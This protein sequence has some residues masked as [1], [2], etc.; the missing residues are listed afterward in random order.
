MNASNQSVLDELRSLLTP[1]DVRT[2]PE[3]LEHYG[4]DW[5][6]FHT[7]APLAIVFPRNIDQVQ[8]LVGWARKHRL[9]LVPSGGRTGLS[10]AA[11]ALHG[12][13]VV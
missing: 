2:D 3:S 7:P 6:R 5:T 13:V 10:A 4:Q 9:G 11:V 8:A 12:E 1:E